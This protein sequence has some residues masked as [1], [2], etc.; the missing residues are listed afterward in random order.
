MEAQRRVTGRKQ[1]RHGGKVHFA[2]VTVR[3]E[4]CLGNS[5]VILS[6][7]VLDT[8]REVFG[9]DF[10]HQRHC[11]WAAVSVVID[12]FDRVAE[13][14]PIRAEVVEVRV[15]GNVGREVSGFL[16]SV[17]GMHA[18]GEYLSTGED[19]QARLPS[20]TADR[21]GQRAG[22]GRCSPSAAEDT[23]EKIGPVDTFLSED[24]RRSVLYQ[25]VYVVAWND[26]NDGSTRDEIWGRHESVI[27][28]LSRDAGVTRE[29]I[30]DVLAGRPMRYNS[31]AKP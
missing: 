22:L 20:G 21:P 12:S 6:D 30:E 1:H 10:E 4:P 19:D 3:A 16:L 15:S 14:A 17:A 18:I 7:G 31:Q 26:L 25:T 27:R 5:E 2:E 23:P 8:L 29:A 24:D 13:V 11:V 9:V 28:S